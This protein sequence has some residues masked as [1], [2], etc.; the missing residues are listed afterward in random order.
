[1]EKVNGLKIVENSQISA[2]RVIGEVRLPDGSIQ[3][4]CRW[5][6]LTQPLELGS[7]K[8]PLNT[9]IIKFKFDIPSGERPTNIFAGLFGGG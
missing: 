2:L 5:E 8:K 9:D 3:R 4:Q 1:M 6:V 7:L